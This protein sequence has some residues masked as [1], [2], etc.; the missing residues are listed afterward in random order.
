[1]TWLRRAIAYAPIFL[2]KTVTR[3]LAGTALAA[4]AL[5]LLQRSG[6]QVMINPWLIGTVAVLGMIWPDLQD[7]ARV[8]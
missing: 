3:V 2:K 4:G 1:M 6:L 5:A 8:I 7:Y